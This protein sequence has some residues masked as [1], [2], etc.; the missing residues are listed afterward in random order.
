MSHCPRTQIFYNFRNLFTEL[1]RLSLVPPDGRGSQRTCL[2]RFYERRMKVQRA[3]CHQL[4]VNGVPHA[5]GY[6]SVTFV[7]HAL[8]LRILTLEHL[9][10]ITEVQRAKVQ[11]LHDRIRQL[12][13]QPQGEETK[14]GEPDGSGDDKEADDG[15]AAAAASAPQ[16]RQPRR[17]VSRPLHRQCVDESS[18]SETDSSSDDAGGGAYSPQAAKPAAAEPASGQRAADTA[19]SDR[20]ESCG[21]TLPSTRTATR[22]RDR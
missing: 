8:P 1:Q 21:A 3:V 20:P 12:D 7:S 4:A 17:P 6:S 14:E 15:A 11:P 10:G 13:P 5:K 16:R 9:K 22:D 19:L 2:L 18:S